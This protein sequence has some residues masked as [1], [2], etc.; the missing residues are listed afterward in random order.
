MQPCSQPRYGLMLASNA[1]AYTGPQTI[2][3]FPFPLNHGSRDDG[4]MHFD[5]TDLTFDASRDGRF[6]C[7]PNDSRWDTNS[8]L[9]PLNGTD[10][11][12][13]S[14]VILEDVTTT[15]GS[16]TLTHSAPIPAD[17][18]RV[19]IVHD[20]S[21][22]GRTLAPRVQ[23]ELLEA[24]AQFGGSAD[25]GLVG[26]AV[27]NLRRIIIETAG[28]IASRQLHVDVGLR[29]ERIAQGYAASAVVVGQLA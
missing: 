1:G 25:S 6:L 12:G 5:I 29:G 28:F 13:A 14:I 24:E 18:A 27:A 9:A 17:G 15:G 26:L 2:P 19:L 10:A 11:K 16:C 8:G 3:N 21:D 4:S 22:A 7:V 20:D 23:A